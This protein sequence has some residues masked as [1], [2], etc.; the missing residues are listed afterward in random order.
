MMGVAVRGLL[1][2][3]AMKADAEEA[4]RGRRREV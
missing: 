3:G 1:T 2:L 4:R